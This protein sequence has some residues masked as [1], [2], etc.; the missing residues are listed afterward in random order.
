MTTPST[1]AS[2][3]SF[4]N[5][6]STTS[7]RVKDL[8]TRVTMLEHIVI[9][10]RQTIDVILNFQKMQANSLN[11]PSTAT[12]NTEAAAVT[13]TSTTSS[14]LQPSTNTSLM[15]QQQQQHY[16]GGGDDEP[17]PTASVFLNRSRWAV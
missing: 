5:D 8:E 15:H 4:D 14:Q 9:G 6:H 17:S 13:P 3:L 16:T 10:Q 11:T 7:L 2:A 12:A 1:A